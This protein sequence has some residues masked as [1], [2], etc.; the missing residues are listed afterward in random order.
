MGWGLL[1]FV[2]TVGAFMIAAGVAIFLFD[3][4]RKFRMASEDNAGNVWNAGSLEWLPNGNYSNR[5]VPIVTSRD[6]LWEQPGIEKDVE[7]GRYY[8]PNAPTGGRETIVT[9]PVSAEPQ[10]LL[11]M[12]MPGWAPLIAAWFT[13]AFFMLLTVK[14]VVPAVACGI[15]AIGAILHWG[16]GLDPAPAGDVDI[17][18]GL[19]LPTYVS[20]PRSQAWWAMVVLMLVSASIYGCVVFSYLYLWTVS[21]ELWPAGTAGLAWPLAAVALVAGSSVLVG[22]ANKCL[23]SARRKAMAA[24]VSGA[25]VLFLAG[26]FAMLASHASL[27]PSASAYGAVVHLILSLAGFFGFVAIALALFV[28]AR[29]SRGMVDRV[30]RVTFD[31]ARLFW[32]YTVAQT[33]AGIV[34]VHGFPR[35]VA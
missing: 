9:S 20:G 6:P 11:R 18:G 34:L 21:P 32:H 31:N 25:I 13:A 15:I 8:L 10:F 23:K 22:L 19:R 4:V 2:S 24:S 30:R 29:A 28:L 27:S 1:N 17:G 33:L 35:L 3:L 12:P 14:L 5:S 7:E 16:W 26:V